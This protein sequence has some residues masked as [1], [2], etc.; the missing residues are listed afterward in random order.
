[1]QTCPD[2]GLLYSGAQGSGGHCRARYGGCCQTFANETSADKHLVGPMG[3]K[4]CITDLSGA[5]F[6]ESK[7][8][9]T[10]YDPMPNSVRSKFQ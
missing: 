1:M 7:R 2:C 8:G 6:R 5:G 9:W 10:I 4:K 3:S